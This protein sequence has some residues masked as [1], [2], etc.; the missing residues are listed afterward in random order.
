MG[1]HLAGPLGVEP[2]LAESESAVLPVERQP[3]N[4]F[5]EDRTG[6][7]SARPV[8][9]RI[10]VISLLPNN[11]FKRNPHSCQ[12]TIAIY[13]RPGASFFG[14]GDCALGRFMKKAWI[15]PS[16]QEKAGW[17]RRRACDFLRSLSRVAR[18]TRFVKAKGNGLNFM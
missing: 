11:V 9:F 16:L 12:Q 4:F 18:G 2:R 14:G 13:L 15:P 5:I 1:T 7:C 6:D 8:P 17:R 10:Q 3:N